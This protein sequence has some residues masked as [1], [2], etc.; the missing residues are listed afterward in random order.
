MLKL[1]SLT[2]SS[3]PKQKPKRVG[4][5]QGS[6]LGKTCARGQKGA[7]S[8]SGWKQRLGY[9]GGQMR[10]FMKLP[11]RGFSNARFAKPFTTLNLKDIE[12]FYQDGEEVNLDTLAERG[13]IQGRIWGVKL[14]GN[15]TLTKKVKIHLDAISAGAQEKLKQAQIEYTLT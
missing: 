13:L 9:E 1:N 2:N 4:R 11:E 15:G 6:G 7:G 10:F 5:G 14:L 12:L 3:R 8:R